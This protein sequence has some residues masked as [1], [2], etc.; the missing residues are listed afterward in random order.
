[1]EQNSQNRRS[2]SNERNTSNRQD[3]GRYNS[4]YGGYQGND[5]KD[6]NFGDS[7]NESAYRSDY[8]QNYNRRNNDSSD[9]GW[10]NWSNQYSGSSDY[11]S[12]G[13]RYGNN[14]SR[15]YNRGNR[16]RDFGSFGNSDSGQGNDRN[17]GQNRNNWNSN[18]G[19]SGSDR[20]YDYNSRRNSDYGRYNSSQDYG[21]NNYSEDYGRSRSY[22]R[23]NDFDSYRQNDYRNDNSNDRGWWDRTKDEVSS[24]FGDD[25]ARRRRDMDNRNGG[26]TS[27]RGKGPKDYKRSDERIR[28]D[29]SDRL[30]DSHDVDASDIDVKVSGGEVTLSGQ[31]NSKSE[32]RRAEDIAESVSGVNN[33]Q[34]H[35][36]VNQQQQNNSW[37][38]PSSTGS[39][40][41]TMGSSTSNTD[42]TSG[43][44]ENKSS[45]TGS[46]MATSMTTDKKQET[47]NSVK[48][49]KANLS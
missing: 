39:G 10:N 41:N 15:D 6:Q 11:N 4:G 13:N 23:D 20:N 26:M 46:T 16:N 37:Q 17:Y 2:Y 3:S 28:E 30:S 35:L 40:S 18:Q 22:N 29:V 14:D 38:T 21:R 12:E 9:S 31:V 42:V 24:W 43:M 1:M 36:R 25:D 48:P 19:M 32:K 33:V 45:T 34:N 44:N 8:G 7:G 27:H 5:S 47:G 49:E